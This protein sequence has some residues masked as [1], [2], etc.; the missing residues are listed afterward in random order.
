[1]TWQRDYLLRVVVA[2]LVA[3]EQFIKHKLTRLDGISSIESSFALDQ[4]KFA[5][6]LPL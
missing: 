3:Y 4:V 1:M 6:S 2:D 5:V